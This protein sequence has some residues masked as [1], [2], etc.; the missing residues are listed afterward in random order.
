M[1]RPPSLPFHSGAKT[2]IVS[3]DIVDSS[4]L[5]SVCPRCHQ[6]SYFVAAPVGGFK[7]V[8]AL[9]GPFYRYRRRESEL[10]FDLEKKYFICNNCFQE[11]QITDFQVIVELISSNLPAEYARRFT[12]KNM[13]LFHMYPEKMKMMLSILMDDFEQGGKIL[14]PHE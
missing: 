12:M 2:D 6:G 8:N 9:E 5:P 4:M 13:H 3:I 10:Y 14:L 11:I 7:K 1:G